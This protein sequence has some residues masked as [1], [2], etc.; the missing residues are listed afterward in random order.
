MA[1]DLCLL[2]CT[3]DEATANVDLFTDALIQKILRERFRDRTVFTIAHRLNTILD[4]DKILVMD[5]G[6]VAEFDTPSQLLSNKAG[7]F[8]Q[9]YQQSRR[10]SQ[11]SSNSVL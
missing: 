6:K 3:V 4:M 8:A 5:A 1:P 7:I 2:L 9:M 10:L 11:I